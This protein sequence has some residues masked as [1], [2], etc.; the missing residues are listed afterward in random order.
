[1]VIDSCLFP[2]IIPGVNS[3]GKLTEIP[4]SGYSAH[5]QSV[6]VNC[7]LGREQLMELGRKGPFFRYVKFPV[8]VTAE[9]EV[10]TQS[11][12]FA[13]ANDGNADQLLDESIEIAFADGTAID[14]GD[15]CKLQSANYNG[16]GTDGANRTV[17]YSFRTF[18]DLTVTKSAPPA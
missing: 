10:L 7:N 12:D 2:K 14:L 15:K 8:E 3:S 11:G 4:G 17:T 1:M 18:N 9:F 16:G 6:S 5:I 13:Q